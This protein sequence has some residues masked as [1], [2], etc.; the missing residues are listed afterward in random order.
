MD[1]IYTYEGEYGHG[2]AADR[3]VRAC[4][5]D[6]ADRNPGVLPRESWF[7]E[8][9]PSAEIRR[10][11]KGKP[12]FPYLPVHFSVTNCQNR[13]MCMVSSR[14]CGLDLQQVRPGR[15]QKLARR[16]FRPEEAAYV[17]EG[18]PEAFFRLWV[19]HEAYGK[20]T[21]EG[22]FGGSIPPALADRGQWNG[23]PYF[24]REF[25]AGAG[26]FCAS[27][28]ESPRE[29]E[30]RPLTKNMLQRVR[31]EKEGEVNGKREET[32]GL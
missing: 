13:W 11:E 7:R 9:I 15:E 25:R 22:L 10:T 20:M 18:G 17:A 21:G 12:F 26:Y 23:R 2:A 3:M 8:Q 32:P 14:L 24:F 31:P 4:V 19:R 27:A 29:C 5:L 1:V 30:M 16:F 6:W 28:A